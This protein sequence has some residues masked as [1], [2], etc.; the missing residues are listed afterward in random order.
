MNN[1]NDEIRAEYKHTD[2][3]TLERAKFYEK[4]VRVTTADS[5]EVDGPSHANPAGDNQGSVAA[6][7]AL[8]RSPE[9]LALP[10]AEPEEVEQRIQELRNDWEGPN[11]NQPS[12]P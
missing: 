8:L 10:K 5:P 4:A 12:S 1:D 11:C 3:K 2:F 6:T 7:L 9:F